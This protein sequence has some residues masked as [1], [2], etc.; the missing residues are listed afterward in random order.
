M[1]LGSIEYGTRLG[2]SGSDNIP[3]RSTPP[4]HALILSVPTVYMLY[5]SVYDEERLAVGLGIC[6]RGRTEPIRLSNP[7]LRSG[8]A[9]Y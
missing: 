7:V 9:D 3:R 1:K 2:R 5:E 8:V 6:I 4:I